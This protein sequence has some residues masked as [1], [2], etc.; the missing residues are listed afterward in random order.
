MVYPH[1]PQGE[2]W[3]DHAVPCP[4]CKEPVLKELEHHNDATQID[5]GWWS[6][7]YVEEN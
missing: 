1:L 7:D 4:N 2:D 5:P 6:C 3:K